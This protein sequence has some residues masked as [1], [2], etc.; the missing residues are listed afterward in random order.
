M[1]TRLAAASGGNP[2]FALEIGRLLDARPD[3]G[4]LGEP[5]PVPSTL[6]ELVAARV[7]AL[8]PPTRAAVLAA[9][10][11]SRPT[12]AIVAAA[13]SRT[14]D[15]DAALAEAE[16]AGVLVSDRGRIHFT[17]PLLASA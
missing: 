5:L 3:H 16:E 6:Q 9:A 12:A 10:A 7:D 13:S 11:L 14:G 15:A 17:H 2:L 8:S 1:L 4:G